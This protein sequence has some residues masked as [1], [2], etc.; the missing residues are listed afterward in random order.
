MKTTY[1]NGFATLIAVIMIGAVSTV[2]ATTM[3]L[4]GISASKNSLLISQSATAKALANA[5]GEEALEKIRENSGFSGSSNL[6]LNGQTCSYTVTIG[7]G[8]TR[9]VAV[10]TGGTISRKI[11]ISISAISPKVLVSSWQESGN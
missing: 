6:T 8:Q 9:T 3:L 4:L 5:C 10:T 1:Q 2:V 11:N 7:S